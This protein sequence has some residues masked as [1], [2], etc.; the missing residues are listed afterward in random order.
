MSE[1]LAKSV[2]ELSKKMNLLIAIYKICNRS[3]LN[4]FK[5]ELR[6]DKVFTKIIEFA[7]GDITYSILVK[8]VSDDTG[9]AEITVKKKISELKEMGVLTTRRDGKETYYD[10]SG[11]VE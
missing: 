6:R 9:V 2:Q 11:V 1:E 3:A 4:E 5:K 7:D 8:R 10:K